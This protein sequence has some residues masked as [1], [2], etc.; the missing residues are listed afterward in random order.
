MLLSHPALREPSFR[1][2][3]VF[4]PNHD[5][6]GGAFGL[7]INRP[8]PEVLADFLVEPPASTALSQVLVCTARP[9]GTVELPLAAF[10]FAAT[11]GLVTAQTLLSFAEP[12]ALH[13]A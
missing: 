3:I 5:V 6:E 7:I 2:T 13:R 10:C 9:V 12:E 4:L 11:P 1:R 8:S